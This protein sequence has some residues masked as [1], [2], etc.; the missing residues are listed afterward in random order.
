M[1]EVF[2]DALI[3]TLKLIPFL[4]ATY[5]VMGFFESA[6]SE[7]SRQLIQKAG[8]VGPVWG[9]II[10]VFPQ[11]GFSAA[12]SNFYVGRIITIGTLISIY[13]S[14]SDE[15]L[16]IFISE[17][18]AGFTI[19]KILAAKVVIG[20]ISGFIVEL[21]LGWIAKRRKKPKNFDIYQDHNC[22]CGASIL[23]DAIRHTLKVTVFIFIISMVIGT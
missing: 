14:T 23:I 4:L 13:L 19:L 10:G 16:P 8:R 2:L 11:C 1:W 21:A 15:M 18:V 5:L 17:K 6:A 7:K 3:D 20:M 22:H 9:A 12:A